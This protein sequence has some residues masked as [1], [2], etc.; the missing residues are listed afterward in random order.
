MLSINMIVQE[1][2]MTSPL[3]LCRQVHHTLLPSPLEGEEPGVR[4]TKFGKNKTAVSH[5]LP[6][7]PP[8]SR[9][10]GNARSRFRG[11]DFII[12]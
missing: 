8:P 9:G 7:V 10:E 5:P 4:G 1:Y 11:N 12:T 6:F 2:L 3:R